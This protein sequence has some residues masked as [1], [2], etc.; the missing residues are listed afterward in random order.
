MIIK[1]TLGIYFSLFIKRI[2]GT[3]NLPK[4]KP[5]ILAS[6]QESNMDG[7]CLTRVILRYLNKPIY[8]IVR[9][10]GLKKK[11]IT[12]FLIKSLLVHWIGCIPITKKNG[13][14]NKCVSLL[15]KGKII[16]IFP[17]GRRNNS[18]RLL[19]AKT[20]VAEIS[21]L[22][23]AP[24]IPIGIIHSAKVLPIGAILPKFKRINIKIGN[25]IYPNNKLNKEE[26]TKKIMVKISELCEKRL[27]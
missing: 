2:E 25:P 26:L 3:G 14:V 9:F 24:V 18:N 19:E 8:F 22:S 7:A 16:G 17:E 13:T 21:L 20:G 11:S 27:R 6:N 1:K 4:N 12:L 23:K 5:F 15:N 10:R